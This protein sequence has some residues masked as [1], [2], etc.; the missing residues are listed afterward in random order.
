M[1]AAPHPFDRAM[2]LEPVDA[3][4]VR[5]ATEPEWANMVG[6]FGGITAAVLLRAVESHPDRV[7]DPLALT[8]NFAAPI[9]EGDFDIALRAARTNRSNQHWILELRQGDE[10]KTTA[11][12]VFGLHRDTWADIEATPPKATAPE[13]I[14][15]SDF[16]EAIVWA[17][18]YD[19]RF[20]DGPVPEDGVLSESST[21]TLWVRDEKER[22]LDFAALAAAS[23]M[24]YPR[25]FLRRGGFVPA[26]TISLTTYFH[27]DKAQID[28]VGDDFVL[29]S[30]HAN[31]FSRG[32]FD[33]SA[34]LWSRAGEL[35]TSSHQL[36]Y[37]KD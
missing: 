36:V 5:G 16:I 7:G 2:H 20:T 15:R 3:G 31:G 8:V 30:A 10:V 26:G 24:F 22:P 19:M 21:S 28:A 1:P 18:R 4:V 6:P 12:A 9:S 17:K 13:G 14:P 27:A 33:Q 11:T 25:V 32:Y 29:G 37:F 34:H 23:D 35:L